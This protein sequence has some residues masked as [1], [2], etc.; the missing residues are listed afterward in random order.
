MNKNLK[1]TNPLIKASHFLLGISVIAALLIGFGIF[2]EQKF[3]STL[4]WLPLVTRTVACVLIYAWL[5]WTAAVIMGRLNLDSRTHNKTLLLIAVDAILGAI[6]VIILKNLIMP[7]IPNPT[8]TSW[9]F[10]VAGLLFFV[11]LC[12]LV[13]DYL[14]RLL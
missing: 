11:A 5:I 14:K 12:C 2:Y 1:T 9:D 8:V 4:T 13:A 3:P 7:L 6:M 10:L